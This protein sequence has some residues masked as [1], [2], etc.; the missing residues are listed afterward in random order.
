MSTDTDWLNL[1]VQDLER[2]LHAL[3]W[4]VGTNIASTTLILVLITLG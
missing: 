2:R 1:R 3:M 4:V